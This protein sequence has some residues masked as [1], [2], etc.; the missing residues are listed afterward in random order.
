M[1]VN[2]TVGH[3]VW[4]DEHVEWRGGNRWDRVLSKMWDR[5]SW[6][7]RFVGIRLCIR[8]WDGKESHHRSMDLGW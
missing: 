3:C 1:N 7:V 4:E 8:Y 6:F 5:W 2:V